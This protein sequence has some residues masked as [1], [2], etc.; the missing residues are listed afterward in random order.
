MVCHKTIDE[1][2]NCGDLIKNNDAAQWKM[3]P[4]LNNGGNYINNRKQKN[5]ILKNI[6]LYLNHE[7]QKCNFLYS[8]HIEK[9]ITNQYQ[10]VEVLSDLGNFSEI[11]VTFNG[12]KDMI[13]GLSD[14]P[15]RPGFELK[16]ILPK[17]E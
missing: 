14:A 6:I 15:L 4:I 11:R 7:F 9:E 10:F 17:V 8:E 12:E 16:L 13:F 2:T 1:K 3:N 5:I